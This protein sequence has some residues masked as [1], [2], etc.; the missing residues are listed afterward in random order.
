MGRTL[1]AYLSIN[2]V[3]LYNDWVVFW[4]I[5]FLTIFMSVVFFL[6]NLL[7]LIRQ[8]AIIFYLNGIFSQRHLS[9]VD[10]NVSYLNLMQF[11]RFITN[12]FWKF[13]KWSLFMLK[14]YLSKKKILILSSLKDISYIFHFTVYYKQ[15]IFDSYTNV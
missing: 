9:F 11:I 13:R 8:N 3:N 2:L 14:K 4:Y 5:D 1:C 12:L 7:K 10:S 15:K 6:H